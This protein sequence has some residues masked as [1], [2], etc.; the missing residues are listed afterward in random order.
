MKPSNIRGHRS[1]YL[2]T[3][4]VFSLLLAALPHAAKAAADTTLFFNPASTSIANDTQFSLAAQVNPGTNAVSAADLRVTFD[5]TKFR[6]DSITASASFS[7]ELAAASINNTNGTASIALGVPLSTPSVTTTTTVATFS[8][9]SL[10]NAT[11]SP[12]AFTTASLASADNESGNVII[13]RTPSL[14]TVTGSADPVPDP[15]P[16]P[17]DTT[18]PTVMMTDPADGLAVYGTT[19]TVAATAT[20]DVAVASV[21]FKLDGAD[22]GALDTE[23]PYVMIWNTKPFSNGTHTLT[24]V[25]TDTSGNTTTATAFTV[26]VSNSSSSGNSGGHHKKDKPAKKKIATLAKTRAGERIAPFI[27]I[28][29]PR[30]GTA[31]AKSLYVQATARDRSGVKNMVF[32]IDNKYVK[33]KS[34]GS[35]ISYTYAKSNINKG[36]KTFY[37]IALDNLGNKKTAGITLANGKVV[38]IR[39]W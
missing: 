38:S 14:V 16:V 22:L 10:S 37:I 11:N 35:A 2:I 36:T 19:I 39:Y 12:I 32:S 21:Q 25:A 24:A 34:A 15:D 3:S 17:T 29:A 4:V 1:G 9:H 13:T 8:F 30:V 27:T 5:Q 18:A 28:A 31:S 26:T 23:Y 6:L 33:K 7:L 20:D